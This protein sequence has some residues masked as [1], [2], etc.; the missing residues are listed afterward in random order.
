MALFNF[1]KKKEK[2]SNDDVANDY[3][4]IIGKKQDY[5][6]DKDQVYRNSEDVTAPTWGEIKE[7]EEAI[8]QFFIDHMEDKELDLFSIE[9]RTEEYTTLV[10]QKNDFLRVKYTPDSKWLSISLSE[11]DRA[12]YKDDELFTMQSNKNQR[13]WKSRIYDMDSLEQYIPLANRAC[14]KVVLQS[15]VELD[16]TSQ[17]IFEKLKSLLID[18]G[19]DAKYIRYEYTKAKTRVIYISWQHE[20]SY[21]TFKKKPNQILLNE[22]LSKEDDG[23]FSEKK[24]GYWVYEFTEISAL[25]ALKPYLERFVKDTHKDDSSAWFK[26]HW[27]E[28]F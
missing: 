14:V 4:I 1:G 24:N 25:N 23:V 5:S 17:E 16:T 12:N 2:K 7:Q 26:K 21:K 20:I 9:H 22:K 8:C 6:H 19:A 11:E 13:H 18:C 15:E 10:Y 27:E 28:S 3:K